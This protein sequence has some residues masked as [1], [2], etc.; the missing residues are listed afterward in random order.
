MRQ[1]RVHSGENM[2][3]MHLPNELYISIAK[4]LGSRDLG[5]LMRTARLFAELL[6]SEHDR[7][8]AAYRMQ[9]GETVLHWAAERGEKG[10]AE[11]LLRQ[12]L[13]VTCTDA[14][15]GTP[16]H[17]AAKSGHA[18]LAELLLSWGASIDAPDFSKHTPLSYAAFHAN[19]ATVK[20]LLEQGAD[21]MYSPPPF[22][23]I[24]DNAIQG[25]LHFHREGTEDI[26]HLLIHAAPD[27]AKR[28]VPDSKALYQAM[29]TNNESLISV[30]LEAGA[31]PDQELLDRGLKSAV[32]HGT[33]SMLRYL[34][35]LGAKPMNTLHLAA[36]RRSLPIFR[37]LADSC[38]KLLQRQDVLDNCLMHAI[39]GFKLDLAE[40]LLRA[41][42]NPSAPSAPLAH[43]AGLLN[44]DAVRLLIQEGA[45]VHQ[46]MGGKYP[47]HKA[48]AIAD[49]HYRKEVLHG[50]SRSIIVDLLL[51]HGADINKE[52]D[53]HFTALHYAVLGKQLTI[54][55][56]LIRSGADTNIKFDEQ[57]LA[58]LYP[59]LL[60]VLDRNGPFSRDESQRIENFLKSLGSEER[61]E[62]LRN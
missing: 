15:D 8:A 22:D 38:P 23:T 39:T 56:Q 20:L 3:F 58:G 57:A 52:D 12:G 35:G 34:V 28:S 1:G 44:A 11:R 24:L 14:T 46:T 55:S 43:A 2:G 45:S 25:G 4:L 27:P 51:E 41:N 47:L 18:D 9:S 31:E 62:M 6:I 42:A 30:L 7:R 21:A 19:A 17:T 49:R 40:F 29:F 16:L 61:T 37:F 50:N 13:Q 32:L 53:D 60:S 10:L 59:D 54:I 5:S 48:V 26:A 36:R 33:D